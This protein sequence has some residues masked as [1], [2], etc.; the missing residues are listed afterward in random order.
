[1]IR[2]EIRKLPMGRRE[3]R[4]FGLLVGGIFALLALWFW[5]RHKPF[6][7]WLLVPAIP[8]LALGVVWPMGLRT[9]YVAW[10]TLA[11]MLGAVVSTV[12]LTVLFYLVVMP[13]GLLARMMGKDF[14]NRRWDRQAATYWIPRDRSRPK[15]RTDYEQQF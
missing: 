12:L 10:M 4:K 3:L 15:T 1:M 6:Y 8:L 11:L 2:E 7:P 9:V 5:W 13:V 14:L